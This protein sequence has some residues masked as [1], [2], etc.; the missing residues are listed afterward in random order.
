MAYKIKSKQTQGLVSTNHTGSI[1]ISGSI[2]IVDELTV[3]GSIYVTSSN[4]TDANV[5]I[6]GLGTFSQNGVI[7]L[8]EFF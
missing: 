2:D 5:Q 3:S 4:T 1:Y 8:G 6:E 7:D